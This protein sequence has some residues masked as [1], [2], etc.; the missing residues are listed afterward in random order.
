M[1]TFEGLIDASIK[2]KVEALYKK[3]GK[4]DEFEF[5]FFNY[6]KD[7]NRLNMETFLRLLEYA[8]VR[9]RVHK[10]KL[11]RSV[12]LNVSYSGKEEDGFVTYRIQIDGLP[13]INKYLQMLHKRRNHV[14]FNV[15]MKLSEKDNNITLIKKIKK[16]DNIID[17]DEL[18]TRVRMAQELPITAKEKATFSKLDQTEQSNINFRYRQRVS[19][20]LH[21]DKSTRMALDITNIK[22]SN[23]IN[24]IQKRA[25]I[26]EVELDLMTSKGDKKFLTKMF[27]ESGKVLKLVGQSNYIMTRSAS[28]DVLKKYADLMGANLEKATNLSGRRAVSLEIQHVISKLPNSYAVTDKADGERYFLVIFDG[29]AILISYNLHV[30]H[31]GIKLDKKLKDYNN[32]IMDGE[33][34]YLPKEGRHMFMAFDCLFH[35]GDDL[36]NETS[37]MK[38]LQYADDIINKCFILPGQKGYTIKE[39]SGSFKA[40]KVT[41]FHR[42]QIKEFMTALNNDIK[43]KREN[44]LIRRKYFIPVLGGQNNEIF[45]YSKVLYDSYVIDKS[46]GCPYILDGLVYHPLEQKYILSQKESKFL[47]YK[48]KPED[49]NSIDFYVEYQRDRDGRILTLYDNSDLGDENDENDEGLLRNKPY[50]II[51]LMVGRVIRGKEQPVLFQEEQGKYNAHLYIVD[52]DIR[53]IEGDIVQDKTVVEFYYNNDQTTPENHRWI[54]MRTRYDKTESVQRYGIKY[55]NY[56]TTANKV[57]R[58]ISNPFVYDDISILANDNTFDKHFQRLRKKIDKSIIMSERQENVYYQFKTQL[59]K[60]MRTFHSFL[61]SNIIYTYVNPFYEDDKHHTVLDL[62]CGRGGDIMKFYYG[63]VDEYVGIDIDFNGLHSPSDGAISRYNDLKST[64]ANF[65]KM[66]FILSD[67]GSILTYE[68]QLRALGTMSDENRALLEK[69]FPSDVKKRMT[70]DR[71][72]CQMAMHY[73]LASDRSWNNFLTNVRT[74]MKPGGHMMI[75]VTDAGQ[76]MD[77]LGDKDR[78]T[79]YYT[80]KQGEKKIFIDIVK[81]YGKLGSTVGTGHAIDFHIALFMNEG[82]YQTEYLTHKDYVTKEFLEK[83]DMEL[84]DTDLFENQYLIYEDYFRNFAKYEANFK[85]RRFLLRVAEFYDQDNE[86]NA[87]AYNLMR[88][89]RYY[90]FRRKD[91]ATQKGGGMNLLELDGIINT[92]KYTSP[93]MGEDSMTF[94]SAVTN[95]LQVGGVVPES[96]TGERFFEDLGLDPVLDG[97]LE[98]DDVQNLVDNLLVGH[99]EATDSEMEGGGNQ[100]V[101]DGVNLVVLEKDCDGYVDLDVYYRNDQFNKNMPTILIH[102]SGEEYRPIYRVKD[103]GKLMSLYSSRSKFIQELLEE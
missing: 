47:E 43:N 3:V 71:L 58:S 38:R 28:N 35:K 98:D 55:G 2:K 15:L 19:L 54:P 27:E 97:V 18:D 53:D 79:V 81:K 23:N 64:H 61:K 99:N 7:D 95:A 48:W 44:T 84:V 85:T 67:A 90:I 50:K 68:D 32:S 46:V 101:L 40:D 63:Q 36:R 22:M 75:T 91:T 74:H 89:Y 60:P 41:E 31:T 49:K 16:R 66:S 73:F 26:Y 11:E 51:N 9:S 34:I 76:I 96:L 21:D 69:Y 4:D 77:A 72:S 8:K 45:K 5:M 88:M 37:F 17:I 80:N 82:V 13:A 1:A 6:K 42:K 56:E 25:S 24:R 92:K 94:M 57:W 59:G 30:T 83:N 70:F 39:Y 14:I 103:E 29:E 86:L 87:A 52:G 78:Y 10:L 33:Y 12:S 62:A 20:I 93:K 100:Q 102:K 65:P